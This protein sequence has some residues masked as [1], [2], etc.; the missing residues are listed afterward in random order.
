[1]LLFFACELKLLNNFSRALLYLYNNYIYLKKGSQTKST[2]NDILF[3][4]LAIFFSKVYTQHM[5][6]ILA[7]TRRAIEAYDMINNGD[8]IAVGVSGGKD[9]LL[10]AVALKHLQRFYPKKFDLV[11]ITL[12]LTNGK[13]DYSPIKNYFD[14]IGLEY[15]I[16]NTNIFEIIFDERKE[17]NPCSLCAKMRRGVLSTSASEL[18]CNKVALGHHADDLIETFF[19]SLFYEGR[20]STFAP[21]TELTRTNITQIRPFILMEEREVINGAKRLNLPVVKNA[22]PVNHQTKREYFKE[23]LEDIKKDIPFAKERVLGA[24]TSP[25]RYNLFD[26]T[27]NFKDKSN[28]LS[29]ENIKNT[30]KDD[31]N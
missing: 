24:I 25:E 31:K 18:G 15:H 29:N 5:Q 7:L 27:T 8:K 30:G 6:K 23:L 11:A 10:L 3:L 2:P 22:C 21:V 9:S 26:K 12:D 14:Q 1:M 13:T 28:N 4:F 16:I 20:L 19:L 17:K